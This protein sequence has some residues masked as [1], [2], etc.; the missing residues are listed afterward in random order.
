MTGCLILWL[1]HASFL[2]AKVHA[3]ELL[4][5]SHHYSSTTKKVWFENVTYICMWEKDE[6]FT[7]K[8]DPIYGTR[9]I[10]DTSCRPFVVCTYDSSRFVVQF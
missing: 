1:L 7:G 8:N 5:D 4:H 10:T 6:T 9:R 2:S 3:D